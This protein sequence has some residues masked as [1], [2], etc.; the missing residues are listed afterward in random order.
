MS[1]AG[2]DFIVLDGPTADARGDGLPDWIRKICLRGVAVGADGVL[3]VRALEK[4]RISVEFWNPDG[5]QAFCGN[6]TRCAARYACLTG[7]SGSSPVLAT[8][9]GDVPAV[10][11]PGGGVRLTLPPVVDHGMRTLEAGGETITGRFVVAGVP[12]FVVQVDDVASA[13]IRRWGPAVRSHAEFGAAG[14]NLDLIS[15]S[16]SGEVHI[17][18]WERGVEGETL[19]CGTGAV[20]AGATVAAARGG[21][22]VRVRTW[23]GAA[24]SVMLQG[25]S[26]A[27]TAVILA[28]DAR[29][30]FRG[31]LDPEALTVPE[32]N[33]TA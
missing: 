30:V 14:T 33:R 28:G 9:V 3:V 10:V 15:C 18:T 22:E 8:A 5:S 23:S 24:L 26:G 19:A 27:H 29:V 11:E 16:E 13:P 32:P 2:N 20:A 6:G 31:E 25:E 21:G 1:G 4:D 17:R 12:H 7:L